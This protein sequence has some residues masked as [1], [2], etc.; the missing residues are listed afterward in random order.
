MES[1]PEHLNKIADQL[2]VNSSLLGGIFNA[3]LANHLN[4]PSIG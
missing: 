4:S 2:I 3:V 1:K